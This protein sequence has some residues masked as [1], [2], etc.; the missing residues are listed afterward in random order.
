MYNLNNFFFHVY[1]FV[2]CVCEVNRQFE[3]TLKE[4]ILFTKG[5]QSFRI[6]WVDL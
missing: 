6:I 2:I 5:K 4:E 1:N 3:R